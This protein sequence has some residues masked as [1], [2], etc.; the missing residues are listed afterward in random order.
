MTANWEILPRFIEKGI[1]GLALKTLGSCPHWE[2]QGQG[3]TMMVFLHE[4]SL[5]CAISM[6]VMLP[7]KVLKYLMVKPL[8]I[9]TG[10]IIFLLKALTTITFVYQ[11]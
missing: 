3:V 7:T 6:Y 4:A 5:D 1:F 11:I 2:V 10:L 8:L 9:S